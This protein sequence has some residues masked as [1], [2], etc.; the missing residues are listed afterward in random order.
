[1]AC[2]KLTSPDVALVQDVIVHKGSCVNHFSNFGQS[3]VPV[4]HF[5]ACV[6]GNLVH[7]WSSTLQVRGCCRTTNRTFLFAG[8]SP[9]QQETLTLV[10]AS[11][12]PP[13]IFAVLL[14]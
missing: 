12:L 1:M 8:K 2:V 14:P 4:C 10:S 9:A 11:C 3:S 6:N 5:P 13:R 7:G